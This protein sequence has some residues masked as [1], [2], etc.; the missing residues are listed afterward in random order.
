M[1]AQHLIWW[2]NGYFLCFKRVNLQLV[3]KIT[4]TS[5]KIWVVHLL[6][7][8]GRRIAQIWKPCRK[9]KLGI[10]LREIMTRC[11]IAYT[12]ALKFKCFTWWLI[13]K[14][15]F[16]LCDCFDQ[17]FEGVDLF[18]NMILSFIGHTFGLFSYLK[19]CW[20]SNTS[21]WM[22]L[23]YFFIQMFTK[24]KISRWKYQGILIRRE[25]VKKKRYWNLKIL[26]MV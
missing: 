24:E 5:G 3:R 1:W 15:K 7:N 19:C 6:M 11:P 16:A 18:K 22:R 26:S 25:I 9:C 12:W 10:W 21:N 8:I 13:N 4:Q 17:Q 2:W 23:W 14:F 20:V